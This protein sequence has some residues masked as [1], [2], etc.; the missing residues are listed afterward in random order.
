M[1]INHCF[2]SSYFASFFMYI[3]LP[4]LGGSDLSDF[5]HGNVKCLGPNY[6]NWATF[7]C[8]CEFNLNFAIMVN[9]AACLCEWIIKNVFSF[10]IHKCL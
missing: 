3:R 2:L 6:K 9:T 5:H 10:S 8:Y 1:I 4:N 7:L